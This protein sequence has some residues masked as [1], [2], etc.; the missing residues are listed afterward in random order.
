MWALIQPPRG[1]LIKSQGRGQLLPQESGAKCSQEGWCG[2]GSDPYMGQESHEY[3]MPFPFLSPLL[4]GHLT[5]IPRG[6]IMPER[7]R[8]HP[9]P[10][11]VPLFAPASRARQPS[12]VRCGL[13]REPNTPLGGAGVAWG[14]VLQTLKVTA[15]MIY[16]SIFLFL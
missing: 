8:K 12:G 10:H 2:L 13:E 3:G 4:R 5:H 15:H 6:R 1:Q 14:G 9:F 7:I 16:C 11:W